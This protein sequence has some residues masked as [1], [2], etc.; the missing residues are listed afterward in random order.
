[1][2][3]FEVIPFPVSRRHDFVR[4][5]A[6]RCAE[7]SPAAAEN[8]LR[9]QIKVQITA[10]ARKGVAPSRIDL[11]GRALEQAVRTNMV[12]VMHIPGGAA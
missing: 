8:H 6:R 3:K 2:N 9:R 1:M 7:L 12:Y 11:E 5:I 4:R 10:M